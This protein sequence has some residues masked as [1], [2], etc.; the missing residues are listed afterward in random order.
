MYHF[1]YTHLN[2]AYAMQSGKAIAFLGFIQAKD[3]KQLK[4]MILPELNQYQALT[5]EPKGQIVDAE[6]TEEKQ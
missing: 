4:D 6:F 1:I 2:A 3:G 5:E